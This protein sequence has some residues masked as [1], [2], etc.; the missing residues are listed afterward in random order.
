MSAYPILHF[1][2]K[3]SYKGL[4]IAIGQGK[5]SPGGV[6][7]RSL[8]NIESGE[9]VCG[10]SKCVDHIL[11]SCGGDTVATFVNDKLKKDLSVLKETS[12]LHIKLIDTAEKATV[13]YSPRVGL[14][15]TKKGASDELQIKYCF[16]LYRALTNPSTISKGRTLVVSTLLSE[17]LP[18]K[19]ISAITGVKEATVVKYKGLFEKGKTTNVQNFMKQLTEVELCSALGCVFNINQ[20]GLNTAPSE[21]KQKEKQEESE[22]EDDNEAEEEFED[23]EDDEADTAAL[24][25][26]LSK[27]KVTELKEKLKE[28]KLPVGGTKGVL[29]ERLLSCKSFVAVQQKNK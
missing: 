4:D 21:T 12:L 15:M 18:V 22:S 13:Y 6:L 23:D 9:I 5:T 20:S 28:N 16:R 7:I 19:E 10:P 24:Q 17:N 3:S 1:F 27:L 2:P 29:I 11:E 25:Q 8:E 14:H 26:Q